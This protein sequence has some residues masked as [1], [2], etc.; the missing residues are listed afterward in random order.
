MTLVNTYKNPVHRGDSPDPSVI[1]VGE[2]DFWA[3]TTST[4]WAP[5]FPLL[6][7]NDLVHWRQAGAVFPQPPSWAAGK[8]WAPEISYHNGTFFVYYVAQHR[9]GPLTIGVATAT[10]LADHTSITNR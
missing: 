9:H 2:R 1:R 6:H 8:F 7:S 3:T 5:Q 4:D 10:Q